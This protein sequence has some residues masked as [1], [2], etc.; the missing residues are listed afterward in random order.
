MINQILNHEKIKSLKPFTRVSVVNP[1]CLIGILSS[2]YILYLLFTFFRLQNSFR[3]RNGAIQSGFSL[4]QHTQTLFFLLRFFS[5]FQ[6]SDLSF[7]L[8]DKIQIR[9]IRCA[10]VVTEKPSEVYLIKSVSSFVMFGASR[11]DC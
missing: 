9:N 5:G 6:L 7:I 3:P 10:L 8:L 2:L 4:S 1:T 11:S